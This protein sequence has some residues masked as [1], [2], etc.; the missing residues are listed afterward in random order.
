MTHNTN[1]KKRL[2]LI[3]KS[4]MKRK[5]RLTPIEKKP[6]DETVGIPGF[7]PPTDYDLRDELVRM[8]SFQVGVLQ[9]QE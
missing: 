8:D 2:A 4:L 1:K 3:K 6:I 9:E 5:S 7:L